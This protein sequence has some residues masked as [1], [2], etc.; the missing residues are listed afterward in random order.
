VKRVWIF[1]T[2]PRRNS[3]VLNG[4]F[5]LHRRR[6]YPARQASNIA[7]AA[8][9]P[10]KKI[11]HLKGQLDSSRLAFDP[12]AFYVTKSPLTTKLAKA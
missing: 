7:C 4:P 8:E 9:V 6:T 5:L 2:C 10:D 3:G 12:R 11:R 1:D